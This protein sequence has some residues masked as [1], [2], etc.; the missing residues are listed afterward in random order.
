MYFFSRT[1]LS[2]GSLEQFSILITFK[3]CCFP[4]IL[5]EYLCMLIYN[6]GSKNLIYNM[7]IS[8]LIGQNLRLSRY[9][10]F[11]CPFPYLS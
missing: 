7:F 3:I 2:L 10:F 6:F 11:R 1:V 8:D 4:T 9:N 5:S